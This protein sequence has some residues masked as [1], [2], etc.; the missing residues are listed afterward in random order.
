[1][2]KNSAAGGS[3]Q[4][5]R[6]REKQTGEEIIFLSAYF[7]ICPAMNKLFFSKQ[8]LVAAASWLLI[9]ACTQ[10]QIDLSDQSKK[11]II[12]ADLAMSD[13]AVKDGFHKALL[14]YA[15][16]SVVKPAE[17]EFPVIGKEALTKYWAGKND[18]T[19]ITW[20]PFRAEAAK[21]GEMGYTLGNWKFVTRDSVFYGFYY[22]IWKKQQNGQWKFVVDGGNNT[23]SRGERP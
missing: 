6:L 1:M 11:E 19:T 22:T 2:Q 23:P 7:K 14:A 17:G 20:E 21:S 13:L 4:N 12:S 5:L 9:S 10:K 18:I 16:D 15:D 8:K 3:V